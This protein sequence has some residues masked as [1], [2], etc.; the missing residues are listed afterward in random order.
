M[1][2]TWRQGGDDH[3]KKQQRVYLMT[4]NKIQPSKKEYNYHNIFWGASK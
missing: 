2:V 3:K 4:I 1:E